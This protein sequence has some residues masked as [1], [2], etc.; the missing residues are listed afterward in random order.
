MTEMAR[1]SPVPIASGE[2]LL[3]VFEFKQLLDAKGAVIIQPDIL[4]VGGISMMR[5]ISDLA[6]VYGVEVAP[7]MCWGP[8]AH[9]ASLAAMANCRNFLTQEWEATDD[10]LFKELTNGTYP[11][12][13]NGM[14]SLPEAPGLGITVNFEELKRRFPY[15]KEMK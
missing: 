12:Q 3:D 6:E 10:E 14:I 9:V 5:K 1:K 2:G 11:T 13:K 8:I 15:K 7:H 4:R